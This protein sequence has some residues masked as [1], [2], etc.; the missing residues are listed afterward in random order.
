[1]LVVA[2]SGKYKTT[3][4][5]T[6]NLLQANDHMFVLDVKGEEQFKYGLYLQQQGYLVQS[7][8]LKNP[9]KSDGYNPF[10]YIEC[11]E[12]IIRLIENIYESLEPDETTRK[13]SILDRWSKII[14]AICFLF[15]M[16]FS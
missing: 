3:S 6:P 12:D 13:R 14:Y 9:D 1:M 7:V 11:E 10:A 8:N 4:I 16:V 15:R 2:S 5:V